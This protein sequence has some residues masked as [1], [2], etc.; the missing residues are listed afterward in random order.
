MAIEHDEKGK[1]YTD[2]IRKAV[3]PAII[4][5]TNHLIRGLVHIKPGKRL[6][7][8][9]DNDDLFLAVTDATIHDSDDQVIYNAPFLV[10]QRRQIVWIMPVEELTQKNGAE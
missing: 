8:E 4:Q 9:L 1:F 3:M 5:T 6:K 10:V 7:D 2:V